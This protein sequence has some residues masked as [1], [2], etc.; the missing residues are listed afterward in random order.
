MDEYS[1]MPIGYSDG[2]VDTN[3]SNN[4]SLASIVEE[5]YSRRQTMFGGVAALTTAVFSIEPC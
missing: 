3:R 1:N 2:D 5:R 4:P